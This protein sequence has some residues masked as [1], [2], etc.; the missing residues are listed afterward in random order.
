MWR[1]LHKRREGRPTAKPYIV[2]IIIII[3]ITVIVMI[4]NL[5]SLLTGIV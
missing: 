3:I 2:I 5:R 4:M 1:K